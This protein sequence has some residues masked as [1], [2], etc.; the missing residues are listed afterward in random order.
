MKENHSPSNLLLQPYR[1]PVCNGFGTV[2]YKKLTC[3]ACKGT[4][5]VVISS[6][7]RKKENDGQPTF[8]D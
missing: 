7:E 6:E 4:G 5:Y 1:C 8:T 3:H 2:S